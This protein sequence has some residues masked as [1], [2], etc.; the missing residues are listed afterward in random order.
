MAWG[1]VT[2]R[3][4]TGGA[5]GP[6]DDSAEREE[7]SR[8]RLINKCVCVCVC[9]LLYIKATTLKIQS[10]SIRSPIL[11]ILQSTDSYGSPLQYKNS[12]MNF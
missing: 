12:S 10:D 2:W 9:I 7:L 11:A 5:G 3:I 1:R 6:D 4:S 8:L